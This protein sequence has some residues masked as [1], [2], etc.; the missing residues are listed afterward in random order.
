MGIMWQLQ[1]YHWQCQG[2]V[3]VIVVMIYVPDEALTYCPHSV[4][5]RL[6]KHGVTSQMITDYFTK[7]HE[8]HPEE[9]FGL[10]DDGVFNEILQY[11]KKS[12]QLS[13]QKAYQQALDD[14]CK[15]FGI[16]IEGS[17]SDGD[18]CSSPMDTDSKQ[19]EIEV[20]D[21]NIPMD[22]EM[23]SEHNIAMECEP[24]VGLS[25]NFIDPLAGA[26]TA[27]KEEESPFDNPWG[28]DV[29]GTGKY[30]HLIRVLHI[31]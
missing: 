24:V 4:T 25:G 21:N 27:K 5:D 28:L 31:L 16:D 23:G 11:A 2:K 17:D 20:G 26:L 22:V 6:H 19:G 29:S 13:P 10:S 1:Y 8:Y 9:C 30:V 3:S 18:S 7:E 15:L 14:E 12:Y